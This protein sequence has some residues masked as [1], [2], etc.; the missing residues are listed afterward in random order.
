MKG[1]GAVGWTG[2]PRSPPPNEAHAHGRACSAE[3]D[4]A[5]DRVAGSVIGRDEA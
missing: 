2:G 1:P 3:D 5:D 4:Q